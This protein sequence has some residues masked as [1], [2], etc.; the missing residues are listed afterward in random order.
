M[1]RSMTGYGTGSCGNG[2][3]TVTAEV[4]TVNHRFL[5]LHVRITKEYAFIESDIQQ[6]VR[7]RMARGRVDVS[8]NLSSTRSSG[9]I[10]DARVARAYIEA[11]RGLRSEFE[12]KEDLGLDTLLLLPGVVMARE[13]VDPK[14]VD[15]A[16]VELALSGVREALDGALR[17]REK[18]GGALGLDL[19]SHVENLASMAGG[20]RTLAATVPENHR[21]RLQ[22]R[23]ANLMP[24]GVVDSERLA[25]EVA[26]LAERSDISEEL[27]RL[28]SH[29]AQFAG[30]VREGGEAGKK[31]EFLLQETQREV[32]TIL[33]KAANLEVT[34]LGVGMK[35]EIEKLREQVQNVE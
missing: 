18:E 19:L 9:A 6:L 35:G 27:S 34:R 17:M 30:W 12:L 5:D 2:D 32:N 29:L 8:V 16:L 26:L 24:A 3:V 13:P 33:S 15:G 14:A 22:D 1:I 11:A 28:E 10:V 20:V 21:A 7:A 23:L 25:Q 4:R 31:M